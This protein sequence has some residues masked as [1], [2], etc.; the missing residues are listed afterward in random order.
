MNRHFGKC[1][2]CKKE[3]ELTFEHIPPRA[4]FNSHPAKPVSW[5]SLVKREKGVPWDIT[6]LPYQNQQKGMGLYSLCKTCN[7]NTGSW[8]GEAYRVFSERV[9]YLATNYINPNY[10]SVEIKDMYPLHICKQVISMFCSVNPNVKIDDL[11]EFV[12]EKEA[13][14]IDKDK[15]KLCMYFTRSNVK[16]FNGLST[17]MDIEEKSLFVFSEITAYPLGFLLY[18]DPDEKQKYKGVDITAFA[19][20]KY[21]D[22]CTIRMPIHFYEVNNW[23]PLDYRSKAEILGVDQ[24]DKQD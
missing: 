23:L 21:D 5:E 7:S 6:G 12:L 22:I 13:V 10:H 14:G 1:A 9:A 18:F 11:R 8:Y 15:Y 17:S 20:Y 2:L 16:R 24:S 3:G 19:N 4:A